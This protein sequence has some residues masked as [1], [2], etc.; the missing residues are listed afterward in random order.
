MGLPGVDTR[1]S[2]QRP[3]ACLAAASA[4]SPPSLC[5]NTQT[6]G[7]PVCFLS[8]ATQALTSST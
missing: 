8:R 1:I 5:P 7:A 4:T 2:P 3:G 6:Q